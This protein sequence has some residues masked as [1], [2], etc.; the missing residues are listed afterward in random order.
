MPPFL[1]ASTASVGGVVSSAMRRGLRE[2]VA[3]ACE[4]R[5]R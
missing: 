2:V 1:G 3:L 4:L 5:R